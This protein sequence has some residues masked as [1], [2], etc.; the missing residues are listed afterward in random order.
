MVFRAAC[1]RHHALF[2]M[3]DR[4]DLAIETKA[5]GVHVEQEDLDP[6][7]V[8]TLVGSDLLIGRST[9]ASQELRQ[10]LR[11]PVDYLGVGPVHETATKP[12]R[13]AVGLDY[14]RLAAREATQPWFVTG[15]MDA[16]TIPDV[17]RA[18]ASRFVVVHLR[19][20]R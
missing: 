19:Q 4:P 7:H 10:A 11:E 16:Q 15:G 14:V 5:D 20:A 6:R 3:N 18:G 12:G 13:E 1:D 8:R 17:A 9:H 2:I